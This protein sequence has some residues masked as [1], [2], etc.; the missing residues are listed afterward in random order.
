M[1]GCG[2]CCKL[3]D[4]DEDLLRGMLKNEHDLIEYLNMIASNGWCIHFDTATRTCTTYA[5]R[6][7]FCRA[8][9]EV[10][11]DLYD[12]PTPHFDAFAISCCQYHIANVYGEA[13]HEAARFEALSGV[14]FE[15][16]LQYEGEE[17]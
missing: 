10:F 11:H 16:S 13:S 8:T 1:H 9:P 3:G 5:S 15:H 14:P 4:F 12:V 6:P 2:A 7:R 17:G